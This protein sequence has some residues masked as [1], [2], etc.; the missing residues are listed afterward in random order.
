M[1]VTGPRWSSMA[2]FNFSTVEMQK[3]KNKDAPEYLVFGG[4]S[5]DE[6][7]LQ[8]VYRLTL[9]STEATRKLEKVGTI[10]F[11]DRFYFNQSFHLPP[12]YVSES[13]E[14]GNKGPFT[15]SIG[16][17]GIHLIDPWGKVTSTQ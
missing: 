6:E 10:P 11:K 5:N 14:L 15:V 9:G 12:S 7:L 8:G 2:D 16:R 4:I 17:N 13:S 3:H 1:S